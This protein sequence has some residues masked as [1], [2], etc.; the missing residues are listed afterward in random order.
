ML[1]RFSSPYP[2]FV[3]IFSLSLALTL[4]L[5][6]TH[7]FRPQNIRF[8][9]ILHTSTTYWN[10]H[11]WSDRKSACNE[12]IKLSCSSLYLY[13]MYISAIL[14]PIRLKLFNLCGKSAF[15]KWALYVCWKRCVDF[16][17]HLFLLQTN[18][19]FYSNADF[20]FSWSI[21]WKCRIWCYRGKMNC[22]THCN[23]SGWKNRF[24]YQLWG[25]D[26]SAPSNWHYSYADWTALLLWPHLLWGSVGCGDEV[27]EKRRD[28]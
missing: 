14:Q 26:K 16:A 27:D 8:H 6:P 24:P 1:C 18:F 25:K 20:S 17:C 21:K 23:F 22:N 9:Q 5:S 4:F 28:R 10:Y 3:F 7:T 2:S 12:I 13:I 19:C 11:I 15:C